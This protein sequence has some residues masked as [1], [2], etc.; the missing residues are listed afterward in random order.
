[1][2]LDE[3]DGQIAVRWSSPT[4]DWKEMEI[5]DLVD[6]VARQFPSTVTGI[7]AIRECAGTI[8]HY[9]VSARTYA[10]YHSGELSSP[11]VLRYLI[12]SNA[13]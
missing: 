5:L 6:A 12:E 1:V 8:R 9:S 11:E 2:S 13:E 7:E 3:H 10:R 4:C